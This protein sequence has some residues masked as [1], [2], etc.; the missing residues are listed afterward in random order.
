MPSPV[1]TGGVLEVTHFTFC[2][3]D[4]QVGMNISHWF[5]QPVVGIINDTDCLLAIDA[6]FAP[7]FK[8]ALS[9]GATYYGTKV[10][11]MRPLATT[12]PVYS[13]VSNGVGLVGTTP[14][15]TQLR[16]LIS[17]GTQTL[18]RPGRGRRYVPFPDS[19]HLA[20]TGIVPTPAY[21]VALTALAVDWSTPI[22]VTAGV[23]STILTPIL[24]SRKTPTV[25][26]R[27][28]ISGTAKGAFATQRKSG[29]LGRPNL[30]PP[31]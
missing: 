12:I 29:Q 5:I 9:G 28:I 4:G 13:S 18:G 22:P 7:D 25:T 21:K 10:R 11:I 2:P 26:N 31:F 27:F 24:W 30:I 20:G 19:T 16:G 23:N 14:L 15:P 3:P 1:S 8:A 17:F 6:I